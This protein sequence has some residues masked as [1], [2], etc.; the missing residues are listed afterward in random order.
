MPLAAR[1]AAAPPIA[2]KLKGPTANSP[3]CPGAHDQD[4]RLGPVGLVNPEPPVAGPKDPICIGLR[5]SGHGDP[6][7][8]ALATF[9]GQHPD[10]HVSARVVFILD[11]MPNQAPLARHEDLGVRDRVIAVDVEQIVVLSELQSTLYGPSAQGSPE[12]LE[13]SPR[14]IGEDEH[15]EPCHTPS[16]TAGSRLSRSRTRRGG[17]TSGRP[18]HRPYRA[19]ASSRRQRSRTYVTTISVSPEGWEA[20]MTRR[21]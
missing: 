18:S 19:I 6:V 13:D 5:P 3:S 14:A 12:E 11:K 7:V 17:S 20:H 15:P 1:K 8:E 21:R 4:L 16:R 2:G 9:L 10:V